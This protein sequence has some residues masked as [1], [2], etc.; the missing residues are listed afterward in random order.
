M[1]QRTGGNT[2][3]TNVNYPNTLENKT[4]THNT[5]NKGRAGRGRGEGELNI[6]M[7]DKKTKQNEKDE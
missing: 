1:T 6:M 7:T 5:M 3:V 2:H 4:L